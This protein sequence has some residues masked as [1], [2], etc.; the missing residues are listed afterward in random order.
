MKLCS[1]DNHYINM[2]HQRLYKTCVYESL[3]FMLMKASQAFLTS[4][5]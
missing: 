3:L 5:G 1:S 2:I 4:D